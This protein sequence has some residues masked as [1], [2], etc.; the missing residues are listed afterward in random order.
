MISVNFLGIVL[1]QSTASSYGFRYLF[2]YI[3]LG[4]LLI[5]KLFDEK[6]IKILSPSLG[7]FGFVGFLFFETNIATSLSEGLNVFGIE[8]NFTQPKY[9]SGFI[10]S[11]FQFSSYMV[12]FATSYLGIIIFKLLSALF[13]NNDLIAYL[14]IFTTDTEKIN[15]FF[16][17]SNEYSWQNLIILISFYL[18]ISKYLIKNLLHNKN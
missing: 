3:P 8:Q 9:L 4:I 18:V 15:Y 11:I 2:S 5:Y 17:V 14:E 7:F 10:G 1:W 6:I 16:Q 13:D 12:I